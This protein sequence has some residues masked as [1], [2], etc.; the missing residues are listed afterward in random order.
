MS[1]LG[2]KIVNHKTNKV[3]TRTWDFFVKSDPIKGRSKLALR[4]MLI[5]SVSVVVESHQQKWWLVL[6]LFRWVP[7]LNAERYQSH[8]DNHRIY[9]RISKLKFAIWMCKRWLHGKKCFLKVWNKR[10]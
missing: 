4:T 6:L 5:Q 3:Q 9:W 7:H 10:K 1:F 2:L 8:H